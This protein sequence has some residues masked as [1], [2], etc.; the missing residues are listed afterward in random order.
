M[1]ALNLLFLGR[2]AIVRE[3]E[4]T[5]ANKLTFPLLIVLLAQG[6]VGFRIVQ[7]R[8]SRRHDRI[9]CCYLG[10]CLLNGVESAIET[11]FQITFPNGYDLPAEAF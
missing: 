7:N 4:R 2:Y 9:C 1:F 3:R 11:S 8:L 10:E 6:I 5:R